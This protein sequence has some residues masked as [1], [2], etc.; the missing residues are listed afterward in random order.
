MGVKINLRSVLA[1]V[2]VSTILANTA[3]TKPTVDDK[4]PLKGN[5]NHI[6]ISKL[7]DGNYSVFFWLKKRFTRP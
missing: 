6:K 4:T 5:G 3:E 7:K 2:M 1:I